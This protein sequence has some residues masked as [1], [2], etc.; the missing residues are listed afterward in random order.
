MRELLTVGQLLAAIPQP[1]RHVGGDPAAATTPART[2]CCDSRRAAPDCLFVCITGAQSDGHRYMRAAYESGCRAFLVQTNALYE[3]L[4]QDAAVFETA[5][6]RAALAHLAS[7]FYGHPARS[8]HIVGITGTKGK[9]TVAMMCHHILNS[10]GIPSGYI[11]TCG[12]RYGKVQ[13]ITRNT[14]PDAPELQRYLYEM[15]QAGVDTVFLEVSSQGLWQRRVDGIPF[16]V[17]ALTNLYP[18]HIGYPEHPTMEH[19]AACKHRLMTDF[20]ASVLIGNADDATALSLLD[21]G[22]GRV[23]RCGLAQNAD[24]RAEDVHTE[25][26]GAI[27]YTAFTCHA[28]NGAPVSVRLPLPGDHNVQNA[29]FALTITGALGIDPAQAAAELRDVR[30]PGRFDMLEVKGALVVIDYA[31]NGASL[32]AALGTLRSL[33][34]VR[35]LCLCGSVGGRTQCRRAELGAVADELADFTYLTADDPNFEPVEDI[36][37]DM[38]AAF[39]PSFLPRYKIIPDR[40][41]AIREALDELRAGDILLLAGKGDETVQRIGGQALPHSDRA[42][43]EEYIGQTALTV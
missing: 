13:T 8:M 14:T 22:S 31:H 9:T 7:A 24:V 33:R 36:C 6:T 19:Y 40:A 39:A 10:L 26:K 28:E 16:S 20:E 37:R 5:D 23:V 1:A 4:P 18:D 3:P 17:C 43:V 21:G 41:A 12:V 42:V 38:A 25:H 27:P 34:P 11:G 32:R 35:L 30:V 29:L 15:K 2:L